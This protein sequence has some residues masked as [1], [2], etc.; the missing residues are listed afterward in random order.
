[1]RKSDYQDLL[2]WKKGILLCPEIYNVTKTFPKSERFGLSSQMERAV[3][4]IP[5]NIAEGHGRSSNKDF[6]RFL[7]ISIG[8][9]QELETQLRIAQDLGYI[10]TVDPWHQKTRELAKMLTAL[11]RRLKSDDL[12][13]LEA[14][15]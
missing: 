10:E 11:I 2:V 6:V 9:V 8:S 4:S 14:R 13:S 5:T 3:T 12:E 7:Y 15:S 1:M